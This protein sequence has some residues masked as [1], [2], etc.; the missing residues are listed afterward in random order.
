MT[1]NDMNFGNESNDSWAAS[2][3]KVKLVKARRR[4]LLAN[5]RITLKSVS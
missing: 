2:C 5:F 3:Q 1:N 4:V